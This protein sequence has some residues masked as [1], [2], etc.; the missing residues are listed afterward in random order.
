MLVL[1]EEK[2]QK[3]MFMPMCNWKCHFECNDAVTDDDD[4]GGKKTMIKTITFF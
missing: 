2:S 3:F 4:A 1:E